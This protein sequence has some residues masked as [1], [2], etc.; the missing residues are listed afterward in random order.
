MKNAGETTKVHQLFISKGVSVS[1]SFRECVFM[2][3]CACV[4]SCV[5]VYV[6]E[7]S[8]GVCMCMC[9]CITTGAIVD[10]VMCT[11]LPNIYRVYNSDEKSW[12]NNILD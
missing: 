3:V 9:V 8:H 5:C 6:F 11:T 2:C 12:L 1:Q 10:N 4:R 7:C